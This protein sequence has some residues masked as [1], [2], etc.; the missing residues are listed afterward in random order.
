MPLFQLKGTFAAVLPSVYGGA[1]QAGITTMDLYD[2]AIALFNSGDGKTAKAGQILSGMGIT[3][4]PRAQ[5]VVA[6]LAVI[7]NVVCIAVIIKRSVAMK[8][9]PYSNEVF[10]GTRD[11]EEAIARR[12]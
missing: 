8:A 9:N 3:A 7:M 11:Y 2:K 6:I 5:G 1:T 10:K 12:A 4:D